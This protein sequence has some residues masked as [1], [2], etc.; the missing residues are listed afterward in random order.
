LQKLL[1]IRLAWLAGFFFLPFLAAAG[2]TCWQDGEKLSYEVH[3]GPVIA[4]EA[5]FT[6]RREDEKWIMN[7]DLKSRGVVET[8]NPIRSS[9]TSTLATVPWQSLA[10]EEDRSEGKKKKK[11]RTVV[12]YPS[13]KAHYDDFLA[14]SG[15]DFTVPQD[16]MDDAGSLLYAMRGQD[17][18]KDREKIFVVYDGP[19]IKYGH[20]RYVKETEEAVGKWPKQKLLVVEAWPENKKGERKKGLLRL[21]IT[22]DA[23]RVPLKADLEAKFGTFEIDLVKAE[24]LK[25][26]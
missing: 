24:N 7:L 9:F 3:W 21:W 12:E 5:L 10:F 1:K 19:K 13:R 18:R 14:S 4:A 6:A 26:P 16:Q 23:N 22:D 8:F 20:A 11:N 2:D 15:E 17:W 25:K